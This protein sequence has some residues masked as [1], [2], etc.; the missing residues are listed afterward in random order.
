VLR[1]RQGPI[2]HIRKSMQQVCDRG[3]EDGKALPDIAAYAL[4]PDLIRAAA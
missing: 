4:S 2:Q 3:P 1:L